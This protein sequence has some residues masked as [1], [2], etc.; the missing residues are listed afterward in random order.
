MMTANRFGPET[1]GQTFRRL[2]DGPMS[3]WVDGPVDLPL[4][5]KSAANP[6]PSYLVKINKHSGGNYVRFELFTAV[7]MKNVVFWDINTQFVPY[8]RH[9]TPPL[10]SPAS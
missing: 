1:S 4:A 6:S 2:I 3:R 8:R 7:T 5:R 9:I 10:Q